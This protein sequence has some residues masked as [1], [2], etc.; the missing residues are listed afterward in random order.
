MKRTTPLKRTPFKSTAPS[1]LRLAEPNSAVKFP[2]VKKLRLRKCVICKEQFTPRGIG[3]KVCGANCAHKLVEMN[4]VKRDRQELIARK[5]AIKPRAKW[6]AEAQASFNA[7]IRARDAG[8]PCI[9]SGRPLPATAAGGGFDAGHY[10]SIG[11]APHLRFHE[12]NVH[13]QSKQDNRYLAGNAVDYRV[14]LIARIGL[15]AVEALETDNSYRKW[16]IDDLKAI[17]ATYKQK[18]KELKEST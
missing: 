5:D 2:Q 11:S 4:R 16:S 17:K 6:M 8:K 14:G 3:H 18:L 7:F 15:E 12:D 1:V 9:S 13:G 10:R